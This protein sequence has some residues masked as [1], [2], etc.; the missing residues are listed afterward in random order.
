MSTQKSKQHS[1]TLRERFANIITGG[2]VAQVKQQNEL[3]SKQLDVAVANLSALMGAAEKT[4]NLQLALPNMSS[5]RGVPRLPYAGSP[6]VYDW[7]HARMLANTPT[8]R[9]C[10]NRK[11]QDVMCT[12]WEIVP[13]PN[14][15]GV[16]TETAKQHAREIYNWLYF[17]PNSNR[18]SFAFIQGKLSEDLDTHDAGV[19]TKTYAK[20][21]SKHIVEIHARDGALFTKEINL[22]HNLGVIHPTLRMNG[23]TYQNFK[24]GYWYNSGSEPLVAYEPHEVVYMMDNPRSDVFYGTSPGYTLKAM[25]LSLMYENE[26]FHEYW[27]K[28]GKNP[29]IVGPDLVSSQDRPV[30]MDDT[31]YKAYK[32]S[33]KE[34]LNEYMTRAVSQV[35]SKVEMLSDPKALG[36]LETR[37]EY[38]NLVMANYGVNPIVVG[39]TKDAQKSIE[40]SQMSL[41]IQRTLW[42]RLKMMEWHFNTQVIADWFWTEDEPY[43]VFSHGHKPR[44]EGPMDVM[45]HYKLYD[46]IGEARELDITE[47]MLKAGLMGFV[48]A[49]KRHNLGDVDWKDIAPFFVTNPQQWGQSYTGG[50]IKPEVF[51]RITGVEPLIKEIIRSTAPKPTDQQA[52]Q[53]YKGSRTTAQQNNGAAAQQ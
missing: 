31:N 17:K 41:Y 7:L 11:K 19:L 33:L 18:E 25:L 45:F 29:M 26:F 28:G 35:K 46:P 5:W 2:G 48:D 4:R 39:Y 6:D 51:K 21:G 42:P 10:I 44:F 49:L 24:V 9:M 1:P 8:P 36:W 14:S 38:R 12:A 30:V 52:N 27:A 23:E 34:Q 37:D 15:E 3:L 50:A 43:T 22:Y 13:L 53:G 47:R 20:R 32:E 40:E 16:I